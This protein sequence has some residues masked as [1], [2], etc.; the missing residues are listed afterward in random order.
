MDSVGSLQ[1][2]AL[3]DGPGPWQSC[4]HTKLPH[5]R[6]DTEPHGEL[7][8]ELPASCTR[9]K[10]RAVTAAVLAEGPRSPPR[11]PC[12][13]HGAPRTR[14]EQHCA[15]STASG[16]QFVPRTEPGLWAR[17]SPGTNKALG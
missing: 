6:R 3:G 15:G 5:Q 8:A 14:C 17:Y 1:T 13:Q 4:W 9:R 12:K 11:L 16:P 10:A 2:E 7:V